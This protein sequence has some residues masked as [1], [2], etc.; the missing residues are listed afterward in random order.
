MAVGIAAV[1]VAF[2]LGGVPFGYVVGRLRGVNLLEAGSRNI[3]ATNAGRVLGRPFAVL[4][5][6]CDFAK[7]AVTT[8]LAVSC[9]T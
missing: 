5:F 8:A 1:V 2:L 3:G 9:A 6:A 7:G 4:V